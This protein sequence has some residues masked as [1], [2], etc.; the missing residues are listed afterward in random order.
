MK[1]T[2]THKGEHEYKTYSVSATCTS[3]GYTV[4]ECAICGDRHIEDITSALSHD[5]IAKVTAAT[6]EAGGHT[7]HICEG[8]GSSFVTD[9]TDAL[10]HSWDEG[11]IITNAT[12]TG[13]SVM[14]Y[15]CTRCGATRL[16]GGD[17]S[18]HVPGEAATCTTPQLCT[19][20]GAVIE[21]ALGHDYEAVVTD[22]TCTEM[23]YTTYTCTRC[24]DS[25]KGDYTD[26]AGHQPGDWII[27]VEPTTDSEG[28]KHKECEVCGE[29]A[30]GTE[31]PSRKSTMQSTTDEHG[32]AIVGG[33]LVT[34][35]DTDTTNPVAG[36]TVTLHEDDTL[37]I[38][39][40][41]GRLLDYADQTTVTVQLVEDKSPVADMFIA[42]TD[43]N[44]N[45]CEDTTDA[46]GQITV[47]GTTGK[48]NEDGDATVGYEDADG[49]KWTL[50]V[51]VEDYETERPIED[52]EVSIDTAGNVTVTLPDGENMDEDNRV[53]ITVTDNER[54]PQEGVNVI[55]EDNTDRQESGETDADGKLTVP[56]HTETDYHGAYIEGYEDGSFGPERSMTRAEAAAIFARLLSER[57]GESI[58]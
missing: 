13:E 36:A 50:T 40:P 2:S 34:V 14:E 27:D 15:T 30:G 53:T 49:D 29:N 52:A 42:V 26:A 31:E 28:S 37:S 6:C 33:Y 4:R 35:T 46:S 7:L 3:P 57:L 47:P 24:G 19:N 45:Y 11:T 20:C 16:E 56:G 25:Y 22:P 41:S 44:D 58:P 23:G 5:Y 18:G 8:C 32:E 43:R 17:A 1:V 55:V 38:L 48:T 12:C 39:L 54:I 9:Y 10:G 21:N 51:T